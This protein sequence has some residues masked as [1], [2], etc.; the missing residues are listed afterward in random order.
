MRS[1]CWTD[2]A[3][4]TRV[5]SSDGIE[6]KLLRW[7]SEILADG[8]VIRSL[9]GRGA[10]LGDGFSRNPSERDDLLAQ[11]TKD[12]HGLAG[13]VRGFSMDEYL[14]EYEVTGPQPWEITSES[15]PIPPSVAP[16]TCMAVSAGVPPRLTVLYA[17]GRETTSQRVVNETQIHQ[18]V[19]MTL[20]GYAVQFV[21][22]EGPFPAAEPAAPHCWEDYGRKRLPP[23]RRD[24]AARIDL[25][26]GVAHMLRAAARVNADAIIASG[27]AAFV[28]LALNPPSRFGQCPSCPERSAH[29]N[30]TPGRRMDAPPYGH[31]I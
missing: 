3:N 17:A 31:P 19:R 15:V 24:V 29:G 23:P 12:L 25:S 4:V 6:V 10:Q 18:Q 8:S 5:Q 16:I 1:I 21:R 11:R 22:L 13:Q 26:I 14:S 20:P 9:P 7:I 27:K 2:H 30:R 28:A